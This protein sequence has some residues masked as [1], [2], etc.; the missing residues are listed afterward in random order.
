MKLKEYIIEKNK[1]KKIEAKIVWTSEYNI[2][3]IK[4]LLSPIIKK[5]GVIEYDVNEI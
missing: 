3:Q 4:K 1:K 2:E 5:G